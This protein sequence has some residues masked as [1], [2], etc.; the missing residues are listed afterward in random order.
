MQLSSNVYELQCYI[1]NLIYNNKFLANSEMSHWDAVLKCSNIDR[2]REKVVLMA[3][4][5]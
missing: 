4:T 2:N 5:P 3:K 1:S